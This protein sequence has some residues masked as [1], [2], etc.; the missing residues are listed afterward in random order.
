VERRRLTRRCSR[1][2]HQRSSTHSEFRHVRSQL[3]GWTL[4]G[5]SIH[6][7]EQNMRRVLP[8]FVYGGVGLLIAIGSASRSCAAQSAGRRS[9]PDAVLEAPTQRAI[10]RTLDTLYAAFSFEAGSAPAWD[11]MRTLVL[12][13]AAFVDPVATG[14]APHAVP[15]DTFVTHFRAWVEGTPKGKAGFRERIMTARIDA[16]GH[17]AHAFVTFEGAV[18]GRVVADERGV[19]SIELVRVGADWKV[20]SFTTQYETP[21][22]SLPARFGGHP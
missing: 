5:S 12:P 6:L 4:D 20:A 1:R 10:R 2:S 11:T 15:L 16:Y 8:Q 14:V 3:N 21:G 9:A 19:D 18:P 7:F 13:G 17:I 22:V